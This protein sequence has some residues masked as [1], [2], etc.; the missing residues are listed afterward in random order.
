M[1]LEFQA[2]FYL[3]FQHAQLLVHGTMP[4]LSATN[5]K[6]AVHPNLWPF[7]LRPSACEPAFGYTARLRRRND[8]KGHR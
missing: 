8:D 7:G 1:K 5:S 4:L 2:L 6:N 3:R